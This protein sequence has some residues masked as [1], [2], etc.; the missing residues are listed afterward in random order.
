VVVAARQDPDL[1]LH[2]FR[3]DG[4][5]T[6]IRARDLAFTE[7]EA[8]ALFATAGV[9]LEAEH[10]SALVERTEGW[11]AALRFAAL[12]VRERDDVASFVTAFEQSEHAVS[13]YLVR[14]VLVSLPPH[15]RDFLLRT[16]ICDRICGPLADALTGRSD[17]ARTLAALERENLFLEPLP[18]GAWYRYHRLFAELLR[19]E[20]R[21]EL[22][23]ALASVHG[24][25]ARWLAANAH[26]LDALRHAVAAG[27]VELANGLVG[28]LWVEIA[29]RGEVELAGELLDRVA[30]EEIRARPNLALLAAFDRLGS[31]E[32]A[33]ARSWLTLAGESA[34]ELPAASRRRA[35]LGFAVVGLALARAEGELD[36]LAA[37]I[38]RLA[39]PEALV[40]GR[41]DNEC[42]RVLALCAQGALELWR[43]DLDGAMPL[44]ER[45][46]EAARRLQLSDCEL[47]ATSLLAFGHAVRGELKRASRLGTAGMAFTGRSR[48]WGR[49]AHLVP[50]ATALALC[51]FEWD[52]L[53]SGERHLEEAR[54]AGVAS[55][56]RLGLLVPP[57]VS[58]W[59]AGR[60][61]AEATE[62]ARLDVARA[63]G[64]DALA[65]PPL[66]DVPFRI[67]R[68]RL[69][70]AD[71]DVDA[72][73]TALE[74]GRSE[75][76]PELAVA[77]ARLELARG[78]VERAANLLD[79]V[80]QGSAP[81]SWLRV[82]IEALV[83]RALAGARLNR[84][85]EARVLLEEAL[86]LAEADGLRGPF[87]DAGPGVADL[88]RQAIRH[89]TAHRWL[90]AELLAALGADAGETGSLP[91]EL[92]DPLSEKEQIVLR[93]LP[94]LMSNQEIAGELFV[95]VNTVKTHLK[96]IYRKLGAS[97][98]RDAVR[99][100]RELRLL[101]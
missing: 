25:A 5:L 8:A 32:L 89:G 29:G 17:G 19:A 50:A 3:L 35:E 1:E 83:L 28:D 64:R 81:V 16:S 30:P 14:E 36:G 46:L 92:L 34:R 38:A 4:D 23:D 2:R 57:A 60:R 93:Y 88:L 55:G 75:G 49:S 99:R 78:H 82:R 77:E 79:P 58:A 80:V 85:D 48:Q 24:E 94:T 18:A 21:Y 42:R 70:L 62:E 52:D 61:G 72:A 86:D 47:D 59:S 41:R 71:G 13:D 39:E 56:D 53:D 90:A 69:E 6:E 68:S 22:G 9:E 98:R 54:R 84:A 96:S 44:L 67:L 87:L 66:L 65:P 20:A 12:S 91:R 11:A 26:P 95:S 63:A 27:D 76:G 10:V 33:E 51:A 37:A 45:A 31:G 101:A 43:S 74:R 73:A 7:E 97:H 100:A 15:E 40:L